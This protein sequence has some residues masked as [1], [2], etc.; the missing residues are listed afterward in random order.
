[1]PTAKDRIMGR[2]Q[3]QGGGWAFS[4]KDFLDL[5]TRSSVDKLLH[6]LVR[7]G[8]LRRIGRGLYFLPRFNS[9]LKCEIHPSHERIAQAV[10][11][12]HRWTI[13]PHG[14]I[15]ANLLG[16]SQQVPAKAV[17]LSNGPTKTVRAGQLTIQFRHIEPKEQD[18]RRYDS[19]V[20]V[21]ALRYMGKENIEPWMVRRLCEMLPQRVKQHLVEDTRYSTEWI[22][23]VAQRIA[24]VGK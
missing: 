18:F 12:K 3:A 4:P 19:A 6:Q 21:Q 10:A 7:Q 16:L 9:F 23:R 13:I 22:Y 14:A 24:E 17:Y 11:R 20:I 15:A 5:A 8:K 2:I 1:M